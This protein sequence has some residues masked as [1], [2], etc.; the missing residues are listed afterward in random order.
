[1]NRAEEIQLFEDVAV[2]KERVDSL[3]CRKDNVPCVILAPRHRALLLTS[4]ISA[5]IALVT[6]L[7]AYITGR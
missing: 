3:P 6:A 4:L 1:M 7:T 2:I 5:I